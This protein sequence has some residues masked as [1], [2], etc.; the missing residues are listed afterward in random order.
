MMVVIVILI[1]GCCCCFNMLIAST[2]RRKKTGPLTSPE[3]QFSVMA[4]PTLVQ[5]TP[6]DVMADPY[7]GVEM[8]A[9]LPAVPQ[10]AKHETPLAI[11]EL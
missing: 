1:C 11:A 7:S 5:A 10:Q 2:L 4:E 6:V 8:T 9:T 3:M